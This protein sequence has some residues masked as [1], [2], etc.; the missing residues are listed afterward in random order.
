MS[1]VSSGARLLKKRISQSLNKAFNEIVNGQRATYIEYGSLRNPPQSLVGTGASIYIN[2]NSDLSV[3]PDTRNIVTLS[4][5]ATILIK[6]KAFASLASQNDIKFMD[7][8]EKML[9]RATKALFAYKVQQ[10]RAYES[11]TKFE[12]FLSQNQAYSLNLLATFAQEASAL[13]VRNFLYSE[14]DYIEKRLEQWLQENYQGATDSGSITNFQYIKTLSASESRRFIREAKEKFKGE[15]YKDGSDISFMKSGS[16][17][18]DF[19][20]LLDLENRQEVYNAKNKDI[21]EILRR[22]SFSQDS[23]LSTWIVDPNSEENYI[24]GP[25]TGVIELTMF[26]YVNTSCN[27]QTN[28]SS[29]SFSVT[30][31][32][33]LGTILEDDI[34]V[35][36]EE[37]LR[38]TVGLLNELLHGGMQTEGM[39]GRMPMID[40]SSIVG[41]ALELGGAGKLDPSIDV[42]YIRDRL[43]TFYLGRPFINPPDSVH[44]FMASNRTVT[45]YTDVGGGRTP[46]ASMDPFQMDY[47]EMDNSVLRAEYQLYTDQKISFDEY[48]AL[49]KR[50]ENSFR[51]VHVFGGYVLNT[52]ESFSGGFYDLSVSCS[53]NM[54][55]LDWSQY[56]IKPSIS[57]PQNI[58]QDPLTPFEIKKDVTGQAIF[59]QRDFLYEN[60]RLLQSGLLSYDS[61]LLAGQN[62]NEGNIIQSQ[63]NGLGSLGDKKIMQHPDGLVYRWKQGVFTA[64][65]NFQIADPTGEDNDANTQF[66]QQYGI[67]V[68]TDILTNLDVPNILSIVI[69]GQPYDIESFIEQSFFAHNKRDKTTN[70]TQDDPLTGFLNAARRQNEY[71]GNFHAYRTLTV[72]A[73]SHNRMVRLAGDRRNANEAIK[74]LQKRKL[75]IKQK[76]ISLN[77]SKESGQGLPIDAI[78]G[79]LNRELEYIDNSIQSQMDVID[80]T[81]NIL[82]SRDVKIRIGTTST[83][84]LPIG[85]SEEE[86]NELTRSIMMVGAQRRIEDVR[87]NRDKNF[88]I[89]SDQYD[90]A[91]IRPFIF[92]LNESG[93]KL[94]EST[95][96]TSM[97]FCRS[98]TNF[99]HM[100]FF[101]NTQGHLEFRLPQWNKVPLTVLKDFLALGQDKDK[102]IIPPFISN[103]FSTRIENLYLQIHA[104]NV[105]IAIIALL[106]KVFPDKYLIPNISLVGASSLGYFGLKLNV[107]KV[108]EKSADSANAKLAV[109]EW[110]KNTGS[111]TRRAGEV[112]GTGL[113]LGVTTGTKGD[114]LFG[115]TTDLLGVFDP[116]VQ[117]RNEIINN[118][119]NRTSERKDS[120]PF[121][122]IDTYANAATLNEIR[123]SFKK[124]F[125]IDPAANLKISNEITEKD[126]VDKDNID[127]ILL[128]ESGRINELSVAISQ[129][130]RL[131]TILKA[132]LDKQREIKEIER[133]LSG[134][135]NENTGTVPFLTDAQDYLSK[136]ATSTKTAIDIFTG[137]INNGTVFDYLIEDDT[138]NMLGYGSG[139]RFIIKDEEIISCSFQ[140]NPPEFT[141]INIKGTAAIAGDGL[142]RA[143][144]GRFFWAG[145]VDFDLWRQYGYKADQKEIP[146]FSDAE[147]QSRPYAYLELILQKAGINRGD[148]TLAGNEFYQP[149]DTVYIPSKGLLYYVK[150]INHNFSYSGRAFTTKLDLILGH[151]PGE[152]LPNP[153]DVIGQELVTNISED[154]PINYRTSQAD[155]RY[156]VLAPDSCL[157]FPAGGASIKEL[158]AYKDNQI[159]FTNMMIDVNQ[160]ISGN[161]Y[162]L[163]RGF[164]TDSSDQKAI[165]DVNQK[166]AV[167]KSLFTNPVQI[168][169]NNPYSLG[170]DLA[171]GVV[172]GINRTSSV[173]G[174][175]AAGTTRGLQPMRLPNGVPISPI[176]GQYIIEQVSFLKKDKKDKE[177]GKKREYP[178]GEIRCLDRRL[179]AA[180]NSDLNLDP[181]EAAGIF[182]KGGPRQ[183]TWLDVR[184]TVLTYNFSGS[185]N[186]IEIGTIDIPN[187]LKGNGQ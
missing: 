112:F 132:N 118:V 106:L 142:N 29:A 5:E 141:R 72:D 38:G 47:Y 123:N 24:I 138:R 10:L 14:E 50:Q 60:K 92:A 13:G 97:Q 182:P 18:I 87:L 120:Y 65:A 129:R 8:T 176:P 22:N 135:E 67:P 48:I 187:Y 126:F 46:E 155:D 125:G 66:S 139:R 179:L 180:F 86:N 19:W 99:L 78:I 1:L 80:K 169:Q 51:M 174:G 45:D 170:D 166:L 40:G 100:E 110:S 145:A 31:P 109:A 147:G 133:I 15:Y 134:N 94:F 85:S 33:R 93:F 88:L 83:V 108:K 160:N 35:A 122:K 6:K 12:N 178:T 136:L 49:R 23:Q 119:V 57:D 81:E 16:T 37:A 62:A 102:R 82:S 77:E 59:S 185:L 181:E 73:Q 111:A 32:Y 137:K 54:G 107:G 165:D 75:E 4:P 103:L 124:R 41:A 11:L 115:N 89:I 79:T 42:D 148:L 156:R 121:A 164:V 71:F 25:G 39:G 53:D 173:F 184:S 172:Q 34:E 149:G 167:V 116:A 64:T 171:E 44:V 150:N 151:P 43:R 95:Y 117:E 159:R 9:L 30:Y 70:L 63:F 105:K 140:E 90:S 56:V 98:A 161:R 113:S 20:N 7:E 84:N 146:F 158:L 36:I 177:A 153:L 52:S 26:S 28:P 2:Q 68:T 27:N 131:V 152:Y 104:L 96:T 55:W 186:A 157:V 76:I 101:C 17:K 3:V 130:D 143:T 175:P 128:G 91:D 69:L 154:P 74:A 144:E 127:K 114:V 163:I 61:G 183:S 21:L 162:L 58:L 168:T